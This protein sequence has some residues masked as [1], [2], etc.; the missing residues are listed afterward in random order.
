M[1]VGYNIDSIKKDLSNIRSEN[2]DLAASAA[3]KGNLARIDAAAKKMGM[4]I[5]G[6]VIFITNEGISNGH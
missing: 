6:K 3:Q 1:Y 5:P 4:Y 2:R